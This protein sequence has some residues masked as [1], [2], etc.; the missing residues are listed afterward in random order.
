MDWLCPA[1]S[2]LAVIAVLVALVTV[3]GHGQWL[4]FARLF[5]HR[6]SASTAP[7]LPGR[8]P[9]AADDLA[10]RLEELEEQVYQLHLAG[11]ISSA[12][13]NEM[14]QAIAGQ[15]RRMAHPVPVL[16]LPPMAHLAPAAS[17]SE[18]SKTPTAPLVVASQ[19]IV[20][21][22]P[23]PPLPPSHPPTPSQPLPAS[24]IPHPAPPAPPPVPH[25]P[26][27]QILAS[28][29]EQRNI[30]WGELIGGLL[31]VGC[32]VALVISLWSQI[33][34]RPFLKFSIFTA[35]TAALFGAGLYTHHRWKLPTTSRGILLIA[36]LL[37]PLNFLAS[38]AFSQGAPVGDPLS[39]LC[40]AISVT[41]FAFLIWLA[42][43]ILAPVWPK[44]LSGGVLGCSLTLLAIRYLRPEGA[45]DPGARLVALASLPLLCYEAIAAGMLL[46]ARRWKQIA[47]TEANA[48]LLLLGLTS[49]AAV[50]PVGLL[51]GRSASPPEA[52]QLLAPLIGIMGLPAL[53][54]GLLLWRRLTE[55]NLGALRTAGTSIAAAGALLLIAAIP[56]AWPHT[57]VT[58]ASAL[59]DAAVF[60]AIAIFFRIPA[61]HLLA[62]AC[63]SLAYVL[64][65]HLASGHLTGQPTAADLARVLANASTSLA[66]PGLFILALGVGAILLRLR[67]RADASFW[68]I[69]A[70]AV[71]VV[72]LALV[73]WHA[74]ATDAGLHASAWIYA[75]YAIAAFAAA[76]RRQWPFAAGIAWLVLL[77]AVQQLLDWCAIEHSWQL[78]LLFTA[79]AAA[80]IA[81]ISRRLPDRLSY[82]FAVPACSAALVSS[83]LAAALMAPALSVPRSGELAP[84]CLWL[85]GI[86]L[87]LAVAW[88]SPVLFTAFQIALTAAAALK[89]IDILSHRSWFQSTADPLLDPWTIQALAIV[90]A[91]L[92]LMWALLRR[93]LETLPFR[94]APA[95]DLPGDS[96]LLPKPWSFDR[97]MTLAA[98]LTA[99]GLAAIAVVPG[100][101]QELATTNAGAEPIAWLANFTHAAGIGSWI[102]L[103]I[104]LAVVLIGL[105]TYPAAMWLVGI[106]SL[107]ALTCPLAAARWQ[108]DAATASALRW[109]S[110]AYLLVA[111]LVL[112]FRSSLGAG[113][114]ALFG[115]RFASP[116][117]RTP[118]SCRW[119]L[120]S[121]TVTPI[122]LLTLI[123]AA[124]ALSGED[125]AGPTPQSLFARMGDSISYVIPL[126]VLILV[127]VGYA[128]REWSAGYAFSAGLVLNLTV[129]LGYALSILPARFGL[130][131]SVRLLQLNGLAAGLFALAWLASRIPLN[132]MRPEPSATP[133]LLG[134][135]IA[136]ALAFNV[137]L[138]APS[139][140]FTWIN[141]NWD[142]QL[143]TA[144][145]GAWGWL[146]L[147]PAL[148]A[149]TWRWKPWDGERR[150]AWI[151]AAMLLLA[152]MAAFTLYQ[153][154]VSPWAG[155]HAMLASYALAAWIVLGAGWMLLR[156]HDV[157]LYASTRDQASASMSDTVGSS[158]NPAA[159]AV[160]LQY[161]T[162]PSQA[163]STL[164][165]LHILRQEASFVAWASAL[166]AIALLVAL[167]SAVS[168]PQRPWWSVA[169]ILSVCLLCVAI[170]VWRTARGYLYWAGILFNLA[171][172]VWWLN[173]SWKWLGPDSPLDL[174]NV[175]LIALALPAVAWLVLE[176]Q[177]FQGSQQSGSQWK[178]FHRVAAALAVVLLGLG[179]GLS[180]NAD[181]AGHPMAATPLIAWSALACVAALVLACLWDPSAGGTLPELYLLG[182]IAVGMIVDQY[183]LPAREL[184]WLATIILGAYTL[185]SSYLFSARRYLGAIAQYLALP[186]R[187]GDDSARWLI[188]ANLFLGTIVA[189]FGFWADFAYPQLSMRLPAALAVLAQAMA[190][191]LL[192]QGA[193]RSPL[194]QIALY[195]GV[196][197]AVA[198]GWALLPPTGPASVLDH[199]VV[200]MSVLVLASVIYAVGPG[201]LLHPGSDWI[202]ATRRVLPGMLGLA[203][204]SLLATLGVEISSQVAQQTVPMGLASIAAVALAIFLMAVA[205][206]A[207]AVI[208]GRD[209]LRLSDR[210]RTV[211]VYAAEILLALLFLHIRL[212]MPYLFHGFFQRYWPLAVMVLA[213]VGVGLGE[214]FRRQ[215]RIVLAEPLERTGAF[216]PLL[217]VLGFWALTSQ[218]HYSILLLI[219][220]LLYSALAIMRRSFGFGVLAALAANGGLWYLLHH[221]EGYG[222]LDHPQL[223]FIPAALCV[224]AA[225]YLNRD[226]LTH[227]QMQLVHYLCLSLIY[228]SST[229]DIFL[230]GVNQAPWLPVVLAGLSVAGAMLG[231]ALRI[232]SF[233][234]LGTFFL[235]MALGTI[236]YH[237]AFDLHQT[238]LVWVCGIL[239]GLAIIALFALFEKKRTE[240]LAVLDGIKQWQ[241]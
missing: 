207:L 43:Q 237:A 165:P 32:S 34:Q 190:V 176:I 215:Q 172:N 203:I 130:F 230:N 92:S 179:V 35:V 37:V 87:I 154:P 162:A 68:A 47:A 57:H 28:F 3:I 163:V 140:F 29:M 95:L 212:T 177:I 69:V 38:A 168:D 31:I 6:K 99:L 59:I 210:G 171:A 204:A 94:L 139:A 231:I 51:I 209:P 206:I 55:A 104:L 24:V 131:Q 30:R 20:S 2:I 133:A 25:R 174:L 160:M 141:P 150:A 17:D 186:S 191:G 12:T 127:L 234:S 80:L 52:A 8:S 83:A 117:E 241:G 98:A 228:L 67:R 227:E 27:S 108:P 18:A 75:L 187:Q 222:L 175:N 226:Q 239:L 100:L 15:R 229:A 22:S 198:C 220:G 178:P 76:W 136:I 82:P 70:A 188:P 86:W 153:F 115:D 216:L 58:L 101:Q 156:R 44:L 61:A 151:A 1:F 111:S 128:I 184:T 211:Y 232:R 173:K 193:R 106:V 81:A 164:R 93:P 199:L 194:Q 112:F 134:G 74:Y 23:P 72:N 114:A 221:V 132:R 167:R 63:L 49:F 225:A 147:L 208:P 122:L 62:G 41:L 119:A 142:R 84:R 169:G 138:I 79:S 107:M 5:G 202:V 161:Q 97:L 146:A 118:R 120:L 4:L 126:A 66:L 166:G 152:P 238:W 217:P 88:L 182:L 213:F 219:V 143:C 196:I 235:L 45:I 13:A 214:L 236:I 7:S 36:M 183:D 195:A 102:L 181:V 123:P 110:A 71:G 180:L 46:I 224:L 218:V 170:A 91:S 39:I 60:A 124:M 240:V 205:A 48:I 40:E 103:G 85:S 137:V 157:I 189:A 144:L 9:R 149:G 42:S 185:A 233:L 223:W 113:V 65:F 89:V 14:T 64:G 50:L 159:T 90:A 145:G 11:L 16:P 200:V 96:H 197:G 201:K 135:Q 26:F 129:T 19:P 56:L 78:S 158:E 148:L 116:S 77:A 21:P 53:A 73:T 10:P 109:A 105:W 33:A 155:Y 192:A 125:I 54:C 121:W